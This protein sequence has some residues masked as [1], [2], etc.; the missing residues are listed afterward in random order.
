MSSWREIPA[1]DQSK[2]ISIGR[3]IPKFVLSY[4]GLISSSPCFSAVF[5]L[6]SS[7]ALFLYIAQFFHIGP[8]RIF[9]WSMF[10]GLCL[11]MKSAYQKKIPM[12]DTSLLAQMPA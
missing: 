12:V 4:R 7:D 6:L 10:F 5:G 3:Y 2:Q 11:P 9:P 1:T 8:S